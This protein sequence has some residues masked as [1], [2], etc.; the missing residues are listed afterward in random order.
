MYQREGEQYQ[1]VSKV[2]KPSLKC[3]IS[4][5][6]KARKDY[7]QFLATTHT[8]FYKERGLVMHPVNHFTRASQDRVASYRCHGERLLKSLAFAMFKLDETL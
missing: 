1:F 5:D 3:G 2:K 6:G 8:V 7:L 4:N